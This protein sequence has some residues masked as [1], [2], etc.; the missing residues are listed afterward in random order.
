VVSAFERAWNWV[1]AYL[2]LVHGLG[3]ELYRFLR[4]A[5]VARR[6]LLLIDGIDEGIDQLAFF[7]ARQA[8]L[9]LPC[10]GL[11]CGPSLKAFGIIDW[12]I[13]NINGVEP[14]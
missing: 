5:M 8:A 4:Q 2:C 13:P 9:R 10:G 3:S 6:V 1:D 7:V 14:A 11:D 12:T